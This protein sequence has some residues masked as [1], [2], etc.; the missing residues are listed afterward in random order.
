MYIYINIYIYIHTVPLEAV[1]HSF[2]GG[3]H[4]YVIYMNLIMNSRF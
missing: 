1:T 4:I 3:G 2:G